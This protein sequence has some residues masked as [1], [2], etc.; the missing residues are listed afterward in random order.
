M[1]ATQNE[2]RMKARGDQ[3][4]QWVS[5][6]PDVAAMPRLS[7]SNRIQLDSNRIRLEWETRDTMS[8]RVWTHT[9]D[10]GPTQVTAAA[11]AAHPTGGATPFN[12]GN[13]RQDQRTWAP[14]EYFPSSPD[15]LQ[16]PTLPPKSLFQNSWTDG[17]DVEGG[18]AV[19]EIRGSVREDNRKRFEDVSARLAG[20]TF[21]HQWIPPTMTRQ[22]VENQIDAAARLRPVSDDYW[23]KPQ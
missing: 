19:R 10:A 21:E 20:R 11:L 22:I 9:L 6:M 4:R 2:A 1:R 13:S 15:A 23:R 5:P 7:D 17:F 8:N 16:R 3:D 14:P 18:G 12:P